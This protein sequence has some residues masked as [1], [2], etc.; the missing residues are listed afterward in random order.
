MHEYEYL[1]R[2]D[3]CFWTGDSPVGPALLQHT[4]DL[5]FC[6]E[7]TVPPP[8]GRSTRDE[9][10]VEIVLLCFNCV[11]RLTSC[12][13]WTAANSSGRRGSALPGQPAAPPPTIRFCVC[14]R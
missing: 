9:V 10:G 7:F 12:V 3:E 5:L 14:I 8:A 11:A 1:E 4:C 6:P 2:T 13:N